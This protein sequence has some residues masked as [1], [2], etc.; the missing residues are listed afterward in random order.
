M[1]GPEWSEGESTDSVLQNGLSVKVEGR[2]QR[3]EECKRLDKLELVALCWLCRTVATCCCF[4]ALYM[5]PV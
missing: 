4:P 5:T 2:S 1:D 3:Q